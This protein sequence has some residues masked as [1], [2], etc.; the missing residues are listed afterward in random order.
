MRSLGNDFDWRGQ[1]ARLNA[2]PQ[3]RTEV[4][5]VGLHFIHARADADDAV[6][7]LITNGWPSSIFEYLDIIPRLRAA[8]FDV[9]APALP[10]YGFSDRP[11]EPA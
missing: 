2:L 7:L 3:F 5:G 11:T 1:E 6:P 4:E 8:G 10:G 9:I